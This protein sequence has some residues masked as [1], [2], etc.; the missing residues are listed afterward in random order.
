MA[1]VFTTIAAQRES[2]IGGRW[3]AALETSF[4]CAVRDTAPDISEFVITI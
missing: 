1:T 4:P 2:P 3:C